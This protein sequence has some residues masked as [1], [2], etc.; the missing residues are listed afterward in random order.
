[1]NFQQAVRN[2][3]SNYATFNGRARRAEYWWWAL[4]SVLASLALGILDGAIF[5][6]SMMGH[7][8]GDGPLGAVFAL[9][10]LLP[11]IAVGVRRLHDIDRSGWWLLIIFVPL[12]GLIVLLVWACTKGTTGDNRF[13][14]DP[15]ATR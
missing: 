14:P 1:M 13:G 8:D 4:F 9:L 2:V 10:T 3:F 12:I 11:S 7:M 6:R 5:G 15:L